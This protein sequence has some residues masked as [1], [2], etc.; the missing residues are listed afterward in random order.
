MAKSNSSK[1]KLTNSKKDHVNSDFQQFTATMRLPIA[2]V[3]TSTG[4]TQVGGTAGSGGMEGVREVLA[5]WVMR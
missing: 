1:L 5:G 4:T 3:W 2:P